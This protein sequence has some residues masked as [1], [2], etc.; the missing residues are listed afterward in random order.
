[1]R[2]LCSVIGPFR[3]GLVVEALTVVSQGSRIN[4]VI[5]SLSEIDG[6]SVQSAAD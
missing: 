2:N 5:S 4:S 1:M 3:T 6:G